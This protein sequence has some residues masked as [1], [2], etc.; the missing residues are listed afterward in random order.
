MSLISVPPFVGPGRVIR[1]VGVRASD[2]V[3]VKGI[4]EALE[5]LAKH[6]GPV[7]APSWA[8]AE[9]DAQFALELGSWPSLEA[10]VAAIADDIA[11]DNPE[12]DH[13]LPPGIL[14]LDEPGDVPLLQRPRPAAVERK[15][16]R[17]GRCSA[18]TRTKSRCG[19]RSR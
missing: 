10:Q 16:L 2:A 6:N 1:Q 4:I 15:P 14:N 12:I 17:H 7:E 19:R 11:Y 8:L 18:S 5:G 3:F 9:A 13:R